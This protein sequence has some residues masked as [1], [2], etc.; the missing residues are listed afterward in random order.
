MSEEG[1]GGALPKSPHVSPL[2]LTDIETGLPGDLN[3]Y[4]PQRGYGLVEVRGPL[5]AKARLKGCVVSQ[6]L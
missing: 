3:R 5:A 6:A 4:P 1:D 2:V